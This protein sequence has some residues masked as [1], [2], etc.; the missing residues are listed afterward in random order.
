M[1][2]D[3]EQLVHDLEDRID[4]LRRRREQHETDATDISESLVLDVTRIVV[5]MVSHVSELERLTATLTP[6]RG[7]RFVARHYAGTPSRATV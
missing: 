5:H 7:W 2:D 6:P 3:V 4:E 1:W